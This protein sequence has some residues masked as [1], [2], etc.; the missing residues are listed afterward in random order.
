M[1]V[2][3]YKNRNYQA[4]RALAEQYQLRDKNLDEECMNLVYN[5]YWE[6]GNLVEF[7]M[8]LK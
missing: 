6:E 3:Y 1:A 8:Y 5:S 7:E 4:A 2:F